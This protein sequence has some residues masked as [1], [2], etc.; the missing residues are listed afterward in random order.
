MLDA[1]ALQQRVEVPGAVGRPVVGHDPLHG[2]A[3][4]LVER[5]R[6]GHE[7][8][9]RALPLVGRQLG[10]GD[11]AVVVDR[12]VQA[13]ESGPAWGAAAA[14]EGP[15][16]AAVGYARHLLDV[17][18][19]ELPGALALVA[20]GRHGAAPPHLA[21]DA[22]DVGQAGQAVPGDDPGAR[23]GRH[24]RLGRQGERRQQH[25]PAGLAGALLDLGGRE[26]GEPARAAAAV[27]ESLASPGAGEPLGG[28][29]A[30]DAHLAGGLGDA[31]AG[32]YARH[33]RLAPLRGEFC[34]RML[35]HGRPLLS[36][37]LDNSQLGRGLSICHHSGVNNLLTLNI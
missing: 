19:D 14:P 16:A 7:A 30:A 13:R 20:R 1:P 23:A 24:A 33:E 5:E 9:G 12:H 4:P 29:L 27:G 34:V 10:V 31:E 8:A 26:P 18:V 28:G 22:V 6:P 2:D 37:N 3:Q 25:G 32:P 21:R 17:D 35:G 11:A 36:G 15:V